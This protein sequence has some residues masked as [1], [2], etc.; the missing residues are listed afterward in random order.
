MTK[1]ILLVGHCGPDS[2]YLRLAARSAAAEASPS[3]PDAAIL[4]VNDDAALEQALLG[5][6]DLLLVNRVLDG[7]FSDADGVSL[8]ARLK[9]VNPHLRLM[10]ISNYADSQAAAS[11]AGALAG[12]GKR[13][14][15]SARVRTIL[16]G[17][18]A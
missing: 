18:L 14:I 4:M 8:I 3:A 5:R 15:G 16:V 11:K 2:S 6:V 17:A 12:F 7:D 13:D 1:K 10:L 9:T